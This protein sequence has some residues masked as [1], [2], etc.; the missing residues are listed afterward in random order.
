MGTFKYSDI[1]LQELVRKGLT[2]AEIA[3]QLRVSTASVCVRLKKLNIAV[4]KDVVLCRA[5]AVVKKELNSIDQLQKIN[6][7]ANEL[8][9][10]LMRWNRGDNGALQILESQVRKVKIGRG[11]DAQEVTEYKFKDPRELALKAMAEIRGQLKLQLEIFQALYDM[12][13]VQQFQAEVLEIIGSVDP[14]TRDEIIRRLT[15]RNALRST[16]ELN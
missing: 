11:E 3:R 6:D 1:E 9:D 14:E 2:Q 10:L 4:S 8:L 7:N 13:A 16:L 15:E 5:G 12:Q